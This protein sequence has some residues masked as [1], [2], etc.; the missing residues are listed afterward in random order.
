MYDHTKINKLYVSVYASESMTS[1][2]NNP[3]RTRFGLLALL[4]VSSGD[5]RDPQ[6]RVVGVP[7]PDQQL[8]VRR[9]GLRGDQN[10]SVPSLSQQRAT[11]S[12][13]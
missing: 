12:G 2:I 1:S 8:L 13:V 11:H 6:E 4:L 9:D 7:V 5:P 3:Y 10:E